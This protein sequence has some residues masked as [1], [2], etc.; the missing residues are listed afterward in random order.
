MA[1][2]SIIIVSYNTRDLLRECLNSIYDTVKQ[3][4]YEVIVVDN[5][6]YDGSMLMVKSEFPWM[7]LIA[8]SENRGFAVANNQALRI[9]K[10]RYIVLLNPDTIV[11]PD[12]FNTAYK[13][14]NEHEDIGALGCQLLNPDK[15]LQLSCAYEFPSILFILGRIFVRAT[16]VSS[17]LDRFFPNLRY[18]FKWWLTPNDHRYPREVAHVTGACLWVR[19]EVLDRVGLLD[20]Q[21]FMYFEETELCYRIKRDGWKIYYLPNT[22]VIHVQHASARTS[23]D[24]FFGEREF[25]F[26]RNRLIFFRTHR[27]RCELVCYRMLAIISALAKLSLS[28]LL[29]LIH[30]DEMKIRIRAYLRVIRLSL[31]FR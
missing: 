20:E 23:K 13:Y 18:P 2:V 29:L 10:G 16:G 14:L 25:H 1:D 9:A 26:Y 21:Y 27:S 31:S 30:Y 22:R 6:S 28:A 3:I 4:N 8:N 17:I 12:T 19:K 5:S 15:T 11:L 7:R 24:F